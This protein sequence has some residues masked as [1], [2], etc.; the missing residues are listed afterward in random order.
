MKKILF[1]IL[2]LFTLNVTSAQQEN[3]K[4]ES[5]SETLEFLKKDGACFKKE[6]YSLEKIKSLAIECRVLIITNIVENTKIGCL[7]LEGSTD[8]GTL[9]YSEIDACVKSL[10][11]IKSVIGNTP[12]VYTEIEYASNDGVEIGAF[13][14]VEGT[15]LIKQ[16]WNAYVKTDRYISGTTS[17]FAAK[18]IDSF[19]TMLQNAKAL[20]ADKLKE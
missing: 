7:R 8:V 11:F 17:Y 10:E 9:D 6:F 4:D 20:I 16:G 15:L 13:Y 19:I 5:K 18:N 14:S 3:S 12:S 2:F 1:A